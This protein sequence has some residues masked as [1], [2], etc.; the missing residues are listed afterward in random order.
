MT[1]KLVLAASMLASATALAQPADAPVGD[2]PVAPPQ[3]TEP[4]PVTPVAPVAPVAAP[5]A[6]PAVAPAEP[7]TEAHADRPT[8]VSFGIGVG[9]RFPT[10]LTMPNVTSVRI[11]TPGG[12]TFEPTLTFATTSHTEDQGMALT[13]SASEL[14]I[15][16]LVRFPVVTRRH[17]DLEV[18]GAFSVDHLSQDPNDSTPDDVTTTTVTTVGYGLAVG[19]W[20][21]PY[22]QVSVS[23]TN[24]LVSYT[25]RRLEQGFGSVSVISDTTFGLVFHPEVTVMLHLYN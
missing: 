13:G 23:A 12:I 11:R 7:M 25:K 14:G 24:P 6:K 18:L 21:T 17:T 15:G 10:A 1:K 4:V 8:A 20:I 19:Q 3:P 9:Y 2:P 5:P 22:L 16:T